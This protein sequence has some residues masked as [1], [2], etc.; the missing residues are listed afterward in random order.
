MTKNLLGGIAH[1]G[2]A[3]R[4]EECE[5][6]RRHDHNDGN[7]GDEGKCRKTNG[8]WENHSLEK[9]HPPVQKVSARTTMVAFRVSFSKTSRYPMGKL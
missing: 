6:N 8:R 1:L 4:R 2:Q 5:K 7:G 9:Q 3:G